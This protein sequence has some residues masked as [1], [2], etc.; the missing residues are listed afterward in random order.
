MDDAALMRALFDEGLSV[1][2]IAEKFD[3]LPGEVTRQL[4]EGRV[5]PRVART[6]RRFRSAMG[7][8]V[9]TASEIGERMGGKA[10]NYINSYLLNMEARGHVRRMGTRPGRGGTLNLWRM[11]PHEVLGND[12]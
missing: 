2:V 11:V 12:E 6:Y 9:L 8:Q 4:E 5:D 7:D 3:L 10:S 1:E